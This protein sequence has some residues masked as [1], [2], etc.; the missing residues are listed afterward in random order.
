MTIIEIKFI[1]DFEDLNNKGEPILKHKKGDVVEASRENAEQF[2]KLGYAEY[3]EEKPE[4]WQENF[5]KMITEDVKKHGVIDEDGQAFLET[6]LGKTKIGQVKEEPEEDKELTQECLFLIVGKQEDEA[7]ELIAKKIEKNNNIYT[8]RDDLKSEIWFYENGLYLP[9]GESKIKEIS[10]IILQKAYTP[11]RVNKVI[12]K[13]EADT[14]IEV[15][16]FFKTEYIEEIPVQNGILNL[17][18]KELSKFTPRKIFFNKLPV[19][20]DNEAECPNIDKFYGD[21]LKDSKDKEVMYEKHGYD[22]YKEHFIEK[23]TM[24]V[25]GGR[26]G[27]TKAHSLRKAF[28]GPENCCSVPLSKMHSN[29]T[30]I[31]ELHRTLI[32]LAGDLS[33]TSLKETGIFKEVVGRDTIGA[34]RKYLRDLFFVNY[35]KQYFACNELPKVYDKSLGFWSK[36]D[37][38]EF[39]YTFISKEQ[40]NNLLEHEKEKYKIR[41]NDIMEK[42]TT[43]EEL[44][45]L[46]NKAI[47]GLHN[48]LKKKDF[49]NTKGT[50]EI[51]DFW[52]RRADSFM[53]FCMDY[54]EESVDGYISKKELRK[55]YNKYCRKFKLKGTSDIAIKITL[56]DLFG[57]ID[58]YKTI[59]LSGS[60]ERVYV[61]TGIKQKMKI[62]QDEHPFPKN[63]VIKNTIDSGDTLLNLHNNKIFLSNDKFDAL[64]PENM[65][66]EVRQDD[67]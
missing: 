11:Q 1:K 43:K 64:N 24:F 62:V 33:S 42:I 53:A 51:K 41:D 27:K 65:E 45:G 28:V 17:I 67:E 57:V 58:E 18:T 7:T 23:A 16:K 48:I 46:L 20:Y 19:F 49:S 5:G 9:N 50:S 66:K 29:S 37:L 25:G 47:E 8:T 59:P 31:C 60:D 12:A 32:N 4:K 30:S 56:E 14:Q 13:I 6:P 54:L 36:W 40:Y 10:R 63:P 55:E 39:P 21:I 44:S 3:V 22:L 2:I 35:S 26:N 15:D 38:F 34:P 52:I 61:W